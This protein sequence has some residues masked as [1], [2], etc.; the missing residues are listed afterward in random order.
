MRMTGDVL[1]R[2]KAQEDQR[3]FGPKV[4]TEREIPNWR[5][6]EGGG[7]WQ[8]HTGQFGGHG[9]ELGKPGMP[10]WRMRPGVWREQWNKD[11]VIF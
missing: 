4:I 5:R 2:T 6:C 10:G 8:S 11:K 1:G 7:G 9:L 3:E